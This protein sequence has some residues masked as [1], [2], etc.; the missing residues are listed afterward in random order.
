MSTR[1]LDI[2]FGLLLA[3]TLA[4]YAIGEAGLGGWLP[5][6][7]VLGLAFFKSRLVIHDFMGLRFVKF[8]W[9]ALLI[10]WLVV[11]LGLI[12]LGYWKGTH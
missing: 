3:A 11:V 2:V 12:A 10:G 4:S 5:A 6:A 1:T 7:A 9:R 8:S